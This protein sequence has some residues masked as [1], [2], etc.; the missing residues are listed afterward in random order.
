MKI[1]RL[2][3]GDFGI[4]RNQTLEDLN[5]G[6]VVIGGLNRAGKSTFMEVVRHLGYGFSQ[7]RKLPPPNGG[8]YEVEADLALDD[9]A[10]Y[11]LRIH[12]Y[13]EPVLTR[14]S[15]QD[16]GILSSRALFAVDEF[17]YR[18]LFT[19]SLQQLDKIPRE[20]SGEDV[21]KLQSILLG[22]GFTEMIRLPIIENEMAKE[23]E[24]IGGKRG[25]PNVKLFKPYCQ[26]IQEGIELKKNALE[27][28]E[29]YQNKKEE[30]SNII[31]LIKQKEDEIEKL[32]VFGVQL[33]AIKGNFD[34]YKGKE[35]LEFKMDL[36]PEKDNVKGFPI[37]ALEKVKA[38]QTSY[39]EVAEQCA[40]Q[41]ARFKE[42]IGGVISDNIKEKLLER[43]QHIERWKA[44][45]S[46]IKEKIGQY[47]DLIK[48]HERKKFDLV[49]RMQGLN[50]NWKEEDLERIAALPIDRIEEGKFLES[51]ERYKTLNEERKNLKQSIDGMEEN[52][53]QLIYRLDKLNTPNPSVLLKKYLYC[54]VTLVM[55]GAL[56][57]FLDWNFGL[58]SAIA[59]IIGAGLYLFIQ[60]SSR[61]GENIRIQEMEVQL[62]GIRTRIDAAIARDKS[63]GQE[64]RVLDAAISEYRILLGL[65]SDISADV[66]KEYFNAI[67]NIREKLVELNNIQE[68]IN[69]LE[70]WLNRHLK[71]LNDLLRDL[72]GKT[73]Q[74]KESDDASLISQ[75]EYIFTMLNRWHERLG[76]ALILEG[77]ERE[78]TAMEVQISRL[79][80]LW[81]AGDGQWSTF[82]EKLN[83]FIDTGQKVVEYLKMQQEWE[84]LNRQLIH[85]LTME[86]T[87]SAILAD[88]KLAPKDDYTEEHIVEKF[89]RMCFKYATIAEIEEEWQQNK[90]RLQ[91]E[92]DQLEKLKERYLR[93]QDDLHNLSTMEN[94]E[95]A[96][97]QIERGRSGLK[98]WAYQYAV[99]S[100]AAFLI[101]KA[102]QNLIGEV[103]DMVLG[104]AAQILK[105]MTNGD[106]IGILP[107]E[108][109]MEPD[110]KTVIAGGTIQESADFLSQ[111]TREQLYMAV[112]ISRILD[113][114][115]SLPVILD[116]CMANFDCRHVKE[117]LK[118]LSELAQTHQIFM[119]TCHPDL[120]EAVADCIQ[121]AQYWSLDRGR[122]ENSSSDELIARLA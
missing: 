35:E 53:K 104:K 59:G 17:T 6:M 5:P 70:S 7:S 93:L 8:G 83:A 42:A 23:A 67:R 72:E 102:R 9:Q 82:E 88:S 64:W 16:N 103:K 47:S 77:K 106:Y 117:S 48:E 58:L 97:R 69:Q 75:S 63:L 40:R 11:N 54:A 34:V 61:N 76:E 28:V 91:N 100:T 120:I 81:K 12:G 115:P 27:Q 96:Q 19:I 26:K 56:S 43:R 68:Q 33:D 1:R 13:G 105:R 66:M 52:E 22:A 4:L 49:A 14:V 50:R 37:H 18:E 89:E 80:N 118:L 38:L 101:G 79:I 51:L 110:F 74:E 30:L 32:Q 24:R 95:K 98:P 108:N 78:R 39:Q 45:V 85:T 3:I 55:I 65:K 20:I 62:E 71:D 60:M 15:G 112:R 57:A 119:L 99:Y 116:D 44:D 46:G 73:Y 111:G 2:Y 87:R 90:E 113:I 41:S 114:Q 121:D 10:V 86:K 25:S 109:W 107:P 122:F 29:I 21:E 92:R 36:H 84:I 31:G 94:L